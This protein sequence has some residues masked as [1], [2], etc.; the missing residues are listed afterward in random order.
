VVLPTVINALK[1][2]RSLRPT[3]APKKTRARFTAV[4]MTTSQ[5]REICESSRTHQGRG[6][7]KDA[8]AW[9]IVSKDP[10]LISPLLV[11]K[12]NLRSPM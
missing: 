8:Q 7:K 1:N 2:T 9:P 3:R 10:S 12:E 4:G 11:T 6:H 5:N